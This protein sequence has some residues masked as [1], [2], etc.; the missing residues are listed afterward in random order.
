MRAV[1]RSGP[2]ISETRS[3]DRYA[4]VVTTVS[5][6]TSLGAAVRA[7][8]ARAFHAPYEAPICVGANAVLVLLGWWL[9]PASITSWLF[10]YHGAHALPL[11]L[12]SWMVADVPATNV[13]GGDARRM[14][15]ALNSR[16]QL[17]QLLLAKG[18]VLW[19]LTAPF[20]AI[21]DVAIAA[22]R[23]DVVTASLTTGIILTVPVATLGMAT[24]VGLILPYKPLPLRE[25]QRQVREA[26]M[27]MLRWTLA[28]TAPY[29][30]VP[31]LGMFCLYPLHTWGLPGDSHRVLGHRIAYFWLVMV[32]SIVM[33]GAM[34]FVG[35][36]GA[37]R[38]ADRRK[39]GLQAFLANPHQG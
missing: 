35:Y 27:R 36:R 32:G 4:F 23:T 29:V 6:P 11:T 7:E 17:L 21:V 1:R 10:G 37:L 33:A 13:V 24:W 15:V 25:R 39:G 28:I 8:F 12:L 5:L 22:D 19:L 18:I 30:V 2:L 16:A 14:A 3:P 9:L 38:L 34:L 20:C 31:A 26:P